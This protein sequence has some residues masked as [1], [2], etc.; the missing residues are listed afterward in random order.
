MTDNMKTQRSTATERRAK[1]DDEETK[2]KTF[3]LEVDRGSEEQLDKVSSED[4][5]KSMQVIE[6]AGRN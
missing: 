3:R 4:K 1:A 6:S 5:V 2:R